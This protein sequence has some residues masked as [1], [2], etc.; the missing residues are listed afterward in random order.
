M[1]YVMQALTNPSVMLADEPTS[2]LDSFM[3]ESVV[4]QL[5]DLARTGRTIVATIH[6]PSSDVFRL[7][8]KV[9]L[10]VSALKGILI[11][12]SLSPLVSIIISRP[13][14]Y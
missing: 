14:S 5:Q 6:Q 12:D 7:F 2:G 11:L 3:A 10:S 4:Q 8:D 13:C 9:M 1:Y